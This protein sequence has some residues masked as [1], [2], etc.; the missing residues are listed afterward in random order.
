MSVRECVFVG[1]S[2]VC[3]CVFV[4]VSWHR[5]ILGQGSVVAGGRVG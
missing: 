4:R 1:V 5:Y 2:G 3:V